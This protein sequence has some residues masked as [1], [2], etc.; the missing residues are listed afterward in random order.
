MQESF[1]LKLPVLGICYV[2]CLNSPLVSFASLLGNLNLVVFLL[3]FIYVV[4]LLQC[5]IC[6]PLWYFQIQCNNCNQCVISI[7]MSCISNSVI[8]EMNVVF[9]LQCNTCNHCGISNTM[10]NL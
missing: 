9:L 6:K 8:I 1:T 10:Q 3:L 5:I 4:F 7:T 2:M